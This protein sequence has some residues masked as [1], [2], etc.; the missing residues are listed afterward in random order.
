MAGS[1]SASRSGPAA[2]RLSSKGAVADSRLKQY[3]YLTKPG[4]V[5][6]NTL[7]AVAGYI[8]GSSWHVRPGPIIGLTFGTGLIIA[9]ACAFNNYIDRGIDS[10]MARTSRRAMV[11]GSIGARNALA[12]A[13]ILGLAGLLLLLLTNTLTVLLGV[14]AFISYVVIYGYAKRKSTHGTLVG[15]VPG[16]ASLIA[17]YTASGGRLDFTALL[18]F[19]IMVV[20][21]MAHF[22]AIAIFRLKDYEAAGIPVW[23]AV[24]GVSSTKKYI[25]TY[26]VGFMLAGIALG[27]ERRMNYLFSAT[28]LILGGYW[29][30]ALY[31]GR[32]LDQE[33]WAK[34]AFGVSIV[35]LLIFTFLLPISVLV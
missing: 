15:T 33:R 14:A 24:H 11:T 19:I 21:Q 28:M 8:F 25:V 12:Y 9:S 29:L 17:G 22:Y 5:Y 35:T 30:A 3:Y 13:S 32:G 18:L 7:T 20:W 26:I 16:A 27:L 34:K 4:I 6:S 31:K 10:K 23:P 2:A 1:R